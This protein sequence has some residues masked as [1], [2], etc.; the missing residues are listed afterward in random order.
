MDAAYRPELWHDL[1]IALC[2]AF[3]VLTGLMFLST[4]LHVDGIMKAPILRMRAW[5]ATAGSTIMI[6][7][8]VVVLMPQDTFTI[9]LEFLIL[10]VASLILVPGRVLLTVVRRKLGGRVPILRSL[11]AW[12]IFLIGAAGGLS[13]MFKWGGGFYLVTAHFC[14]AIGFLV[15]A[16]WSLMVDVESQAYRNATQ[17]GGD[18]MST[19][20]SNPHLRIGEAP[21]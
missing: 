3:A 14:F 20:Y 10:N 19:N 16:A 18:T 4:S 7:E 1:Y 6:I 15:V 21:S 11:C 9:G 2:G 5:T 13:L 8:A 12:S 17:T